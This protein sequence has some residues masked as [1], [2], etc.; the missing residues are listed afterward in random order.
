[1]ADQTNT[2]PCGYC[3]R[4]MPATITTDRGTGFTY[5]VDCWTA[6]QTLSTLEAQLEMARRALGAS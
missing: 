1:M 3:D 6:R 2:R 4:V 5:C